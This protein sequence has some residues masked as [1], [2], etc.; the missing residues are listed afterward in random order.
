[1]TEPLRWVAPAEA[2][3]DVIPEVPPLMAS[4]EGDRVVVTMGVEGDTIRLTFNLRF[5]G[6]TVSI[7]EVERLVQ[8]VV[9]CILSRVE[10]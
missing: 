8:D 5:D 4:F 9:A 3:Y 1:M 2:G 7:A 6:R 10:P